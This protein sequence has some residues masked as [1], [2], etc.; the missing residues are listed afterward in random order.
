[1]EKNSNRGKVT[2]FVPITYGCDSFCTYC[3]VPHTRGRLISRPKIEIIDEIKAL[4]NVG[5]VEVILLGQNVNVYGMDKGE[6]DGFAEL[7][8][9]VNDIDGLKRIR[10]L[11]SHP[12]DMTLETIEQMK[13]LAKM[14]PYFHLPIQAGNDE[15]LRRM[16]RGYT[17]ESYKRLIG[18]I[19]STFPLRGLT[20][21]LIVGFPG[22]T[23]E[24]FDDSMRVLEEIRFDQVYSA[25]YSKRPKTPAANFVDQVD[26]KELNRR[27]NIV[28][29][30]QREIASENA[31]KNIGL[32]HNVLIE[33]CLEG[34]SV[35]MSGTGKFRAKLTK[36]SRQAISIKSKFWKPEMAQCWGKQL[37]IPEFVAN[38]Q[39]SLSARF[40]QID[41]IADANIEKV[42]KAFADVG[43]T[44]GDLAGSTGYGLGD[45]SRDKL[46]R[47]YS[48]IFITEAALVRPQIA[49][50][51]PRSDLCTVWNPST[52]R[53]C[54][55]DNRNA[56]R[57]P[58]GS[59]RHQTGKGFF[60]RVWHQVC[61]VRL[62]FRNPKPRICQ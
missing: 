56:I 11:T 41:A 39:R 13:G 61:P 51:T 57:N 26:E 8:Q 17:I 37:N 15:V 20:T 2:A 62:A 58:S 54:G 30:R 24:M 27:I 36:H 33:D 42:L 47:V 1:M 32:V 48:M 9:E 52:R 50:G 6:N 4:I 31:K 46:E 25:Q 29:E 23:E 22:E 5:T 34:M 44:T 12:R 28:V 43:L 35:G 60:G 18:K 59:N 19:N 10:F 7:L 3:I 49:S 45:I 38:C 21:D 55:F 53:P 40:E 14:A 16:N